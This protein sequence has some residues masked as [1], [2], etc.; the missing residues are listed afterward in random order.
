MEMKFSRHGRTWVFHNADDIDIRD[1]LPPENFV[2]TQNP[3]TKELYLEETE[4]FIPVKKIYGDT[5]ERAARIIN[6]FES[7]GRNMGVLLSGLPGSG[8]TMLTKVVSKMCADKG[9]PTILITQPWYGEAFATFL[10]QIH[11]PCVVLF[12]EFEKVYNR[13]QQ[14]AMLTILD[15][16][17]SGNKLFM[18]TCN[19]VY[20]I[21]QLMINRP[22]RI[23]YALNYTGLSEAFIREYCE[24]MLDNKA[25]VEHV[26]RTATLFAEFNF[27]MLQALV[28]DM[29]RYNESPLQTLDYLNAKPDKSVGTYTVQLFKSGKLIDA[30]GDDRYYPQ[31]LDKAPFDAKGFSI[32]HYIYNDEGEQ[33][34]TEQL[35]FTPEHMTR[36]DATTKSYEFV[37]GDYRVLVTLQVQKHSGLAFA[38]SDLT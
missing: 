7:R 31:T 29:N 13:E 16:V 9:M 23:F 19:D 30:D 36:I 38:Y 32:N 4:P 10:Q 34:W 28:D 35:H 3:V 14:Q 25:Y 2:L 21:D 11:Q 20:R 37:R 26:V 1:Q 17:F 12:D 22:G 33:E 18:L 24:D 15:G 6:T 8:K 27:D 5:N